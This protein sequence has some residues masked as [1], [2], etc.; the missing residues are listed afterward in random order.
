[1]LEGRAKHGKS[2]LEAEQPWDT[3]ESACLEDKKTLE[4]VTDGP[5]IYLESG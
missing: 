2:R 4:P 3:R 1:M 5:R